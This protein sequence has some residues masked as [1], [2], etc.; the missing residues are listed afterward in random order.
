[1]IVKLDKSRAIRVEVENSLKVYDVL[2]DRAA[3]VLGEPV[4]TWWTSGDDS[5][6]TG[7]ASGAKIGGTS[8]ARF[9]NNSMVEGPPGA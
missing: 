5:H 4:F 2:K 3:K 8:R 7:G 9:V 6:S 1:V